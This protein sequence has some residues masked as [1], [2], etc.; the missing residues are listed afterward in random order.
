MST[1]TKSTAPLFLVLMGTLAFSLSAL[2]GHKSE[3]ATTLSSE[4]AHDCDQMS[5]S[6]QGGEEQGRCE[7]KP[8]S[9]RDDLAKLLAK[10]N[11]KKGTS[12]YRD[13]EDRVQ[14]AEGWQIDIEWLCKEG[15]PDKCP[16]ISP[17]HTS[18][19]RSKD[20]TEKILSAVKAN[21][22]SV[23]E[24]IKTASRDRK[25]IDDCIIDSETKEEIPESRRMS[26][27]I[28]RMRD[29]SASKAADYYETEIHPQ[30]EAKV[31]SND[32]RQQREGYALLQELTKAQAGGKFVR[33]SVEELTM[34]GK[35]KASA[36]VEQQKI[37]AMQADIQQTPT[38]A[39]RTQKMQLMQAEILKMR[40]M[41]MSLSQRL[42]KSAADVNAMPWSSG[43]SFANTLTGNLTDYQAHLE[44]TFG[45]ITQNHELMVSPVTNNPTGDAAIQHGDPRTVRA[46]TPV[47]GLQNYSPN[48]PIAPSA[49]QAQLDRAGR[50]VPTQFNKST[51]GI[52]QVG[53]QVRIK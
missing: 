7:V 8:L 49:P 6:I 39:L 5:D 50:P 13:S 38:G 9:G 36:V 44:Q 27:K 14:T 26:C 43:Y 28:D 20:I 12:K 31:G 25:D 19:A 11:V 23:S 22:R 15:D 52:P 18:T 42:G 29:M 53:S 45:T 51:S 46:G 30:L 32:P 33:E 21:A 48:A 1:K 40:Q 4:F 2:P 35:M 3:G 47:T 10:V 34:Y 24:K 41:E 37:M 17:I 16:R